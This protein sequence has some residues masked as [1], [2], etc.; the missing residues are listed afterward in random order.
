MCLETAKKGGQLKYNRLFCILLLI[1]S[2]LITVYGQNFNTDSMKAVIAG[3]RETKAKA[4]NL[5]LLAKSYFNINDDSLLKY[6]GYAARVAGSTGNFS[7]L[8][9]AD[10]FIG[11]YFSLNADFEKALFYNQRA[12]QVADSI[13]ETTLVAKA[14]LNAGN[15][16]NNLRRP[17]ESRIYLKKSLK[18]FESIDDSAGIIAVYINLGGSFSDDACY[19]S[20]MVY[21]SK[22]MAISENTARKPYLENICFSLSIAYYELGQYDHA[23]RFAER[24]LA[25]YENKG[26]KSGVGQCINLLGNIDKATMNYQGA[27]ANYNRALELFAQ[28]SDSLSLYNI[29]NNLG[30]MFEEQGKLS[31]AG[32]Y[33]STA[34]NGYK[35]LDYVKGIVLVMKNQAMILSETGRYREAIALNDSVI[36]L[37]DQHELNLYLKDALWNN[38]E[39]YLKLGDYRSAFGYQQRYYLLKDSIYTIEKEQLIEDLKFRYEKEKDLAQIV[40]L[41]K[42]NLKKDLTLKQRTIQRNAFIFTVIIIMVVGSF[43]LLLLNQR[44]KKDGIIAQQH[45]RQLEEEKKLMAAKALVEGQEEERKRIARD[46]HDGLGVLLS[47]TKMQF[48]SIRDTNPENLPL[49]RKATQLLEQATG[50]VR[51]ISH[52]MMPGLLMKLGLYEAVGDLFDNLGDKGTLEV[53][54]DIQENLERLPENQEIMLYRIVQEMVN[55]TLRHANANKISLLLH[56]TD[57]NLH[58]TYSDDGKG[59]DVN[60]MMEGKSLGLKSIKSRVDFLNGK[61]TIQSEPSEGTTYFI[62]IPAKLQNIQST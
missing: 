45:I 47:A 32:R 10:I 52:N 29:Y 25:I 24:S 4:D 48:T 20:A 28:L 26:N 34:L 15:N 30:S 53:N 2:T 17:E 38:A 1:L 19:D 61:L 23:R 16:L 3:Q 58:L 6:A 7:A 59:F 12:F 42:E 27:F 13:G 37:A 21:F 35:K 56:E 50:D 55:N 57:G 46:L 43:M 11:R 51:V 39:N 31:E 62:N 18:A 41:E 8:A 49:I 22:G 9:Q 14:A 33:Y 60:K 5:N 54:C 36:A 44:R 40:E